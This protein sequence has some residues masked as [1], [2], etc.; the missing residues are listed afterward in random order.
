MFH[1]LSKTLLIEPQKKKGKQRTA[2]Q[3]QADLL[4]EWSEGRIRAPTE[5]ETDIVLRDY[6]AENL[7]EWIRRYFKL[8]ESSGQFHSDDWPTE[9]ELEA[10][11]RTI[12]KQVMHSDMMYSKELF[13][14]AVD[15]FPDTG[16]LE[17]LY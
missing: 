17:P 8:N 4:E 14:L 16:S 5:E 12:V 1:P 10:E 7:R 11:L 15:E 13:M 2:K 9:E 3:I 6:S